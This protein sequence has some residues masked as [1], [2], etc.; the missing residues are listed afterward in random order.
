MAGN[1]TG[2]SGRTKSINMTLTNGVLQI[3]AACMHHRVMS[4]RTEYFSTLAREDWER[5][6]RP[7]VPKS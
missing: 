3:A 2:D 5:R 4:N 6:G 1:A 7:E